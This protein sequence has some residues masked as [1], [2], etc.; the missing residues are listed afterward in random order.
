MKGAD[1]FII[2]LAER[3]AP[4]EIDTAPAVLAA[5]ER[6][7]DAW[8]A[9]LRGDPKTVI[10]GWMGLADV[11]AIIPHVIAAV[12]AHWPN[13]AAT[14]SHWP[15]VAAT[16]KTNWPIVE[17]ALQA[18][19]VAIH[20]AETIRAIQTWA[21]GGG[22]SS[23]ADAA[24]PSTVAQLLEAMSEELRRQG[25]EPRKATEAAAATVEALAGNPENA[26]A[27]LAA[28]KPR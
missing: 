5:A 24:L 26:A 7:G 18:S 28:V 4:D 27:F 8:K 22:Q 17:T 11:V 23:G 19:V 14:V 10:G 2:A 15:N 16:V 3:I 12:Q 13:V 21:D 9:V 25:V 6:G 20:S 1:A